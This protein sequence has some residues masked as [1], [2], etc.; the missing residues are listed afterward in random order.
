[1]LQTFILEVEFSD[2]LQVRFLYD[3]E[4]YFDSSLWY[5]FQLM[6]LAELYFIAI[7]V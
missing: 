6:G 4:E 7:N 2:Q 3:R 5:G 1:M